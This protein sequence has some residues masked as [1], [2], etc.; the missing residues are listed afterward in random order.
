MVDT[1]RS[2]K[3][4]L[5]NRQFEA[6]GPDKLWRAAAT[7]LMLPTLRHDAGSRAAEECH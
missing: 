5:V 2:Q 7:W 4:D 1:S 6:D 3:E